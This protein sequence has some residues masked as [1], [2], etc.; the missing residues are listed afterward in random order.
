[1]TSSK[2]ITK[3]DAQKQMVEYSFGLK[4]HD[5][6]CFEVGVFL[7]FLEFNINLRA[8]SQNFVE[9]HRFDV[10]LSYFKHILDMYQFN[11]TY[12]HITFF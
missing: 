8:S 9:N 4:Y 6:K 12:L 10:V 7:M 2:L 3:S 5:P 1:M 11:I